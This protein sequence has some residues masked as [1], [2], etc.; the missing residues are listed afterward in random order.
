MRPV[1]PPLRLPAGVAVD[2]V[3]WLPSGARSGLVRVRGRR[4][5]G[6]P[7]RLPDLGLDHSD[8]AQRFISLPDPRADR[9]PAGW[10]GAYVVDVALASS[11]TAWALE[12]ADG[13]RM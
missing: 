9:D 10:R 2:A 3:D 7:W 5:E 11:A 12:W 6:E 13:P 1:P 4:V 8:G